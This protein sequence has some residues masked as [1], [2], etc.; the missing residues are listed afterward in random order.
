MNTNNE[1]LFHEALRK[2]RKELKMSQTELAV[3]SGISL[4]SVRRYE[5][6][7]SFPDM[8][9]FN[10]LN[11]V[12]KNGV[13]ASL[14]ACLFCKFNS[15]DTSADTLLKEI[16]DNVQNAFFSNLIEKG[17]KEFIDYLYKLTNIFMTM[18]GK[19]INEVIHFS[20]LMSRVP[21]FKADYLWA[22]QDQHPPEG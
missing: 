15:I 18:N 13:L 19:G 3:R 21:D 20:E 9:R 4:M 7:E 8:K 11:A 5:T 17:N 6:G 12:L 22:Y 2:V 14:W 1:V 16:S 10:K